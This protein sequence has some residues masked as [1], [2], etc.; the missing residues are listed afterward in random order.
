VLGNAVADRLPSADARHWRKS[1]SAWQQ[2]GG[3]KLGE[4]RDFRNL[5]PNPWPVEAVIMPYPGKRCYGKGELIFCEIKLLGDEADHRLILEVIV[6]ALEEL[7]SRRDSRWNYS[8][9]LWG[10]FD[11]HAVYTAAGEKWTSLVREGQLDLNLRPDPLQWSQGMRFSPCLKRPRDRMRWITP[12]HSP[13]EKG[14]GTARIQERIPSLAA[15]LD[16]LALRLSGLMSGKKYY[17][18][19]NFWEMLSEEQAQTF[20]EARIAVSRIPMIEYETHAG[21]AWQLDQN[22]GTQIFSTRIPEEVYPW[23]ALASV[24]HIGDYT[25]FGWGTFVIN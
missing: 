18:L 7:G 21:S 24:L 23:F 4:R 17:T 19:Q 3:M 22:T 5:P 14:E 1:L 6:P 13:D 15:I 25:H 9:C 12:F 8:N 16:A 11:I 10:H 20:R 2:F